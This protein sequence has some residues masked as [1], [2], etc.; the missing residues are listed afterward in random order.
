MCYL[1]IIISYVVLISKI[2]IYPRI[3]ADLNLEQKDT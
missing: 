3:W 1:K 2:G